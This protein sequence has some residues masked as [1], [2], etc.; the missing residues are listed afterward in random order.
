[1]ND[2]PGP[3]DS[4]SSG[5]TAR[6]F[7]GW[8]VL[9]CCCLLAVFGGAVVHSSTLFVVPMSEELGLTPG[10][11]ALIFLY[12]TA[13]TALIGPLVGWLADRFGSRPLVLIGGLAAGVGL[14]LSS[15]ASSHWQFLATF[16]VAFAGTTAG[17]S[18]I[19]L[20]SL[21]NRW[22]SRRRPV[23]MATLMTMFALG[24]T[25]VPLPVAWG[26][27]ALGWRNSL[28]VLGVFLCVL[29]AIAGMVL[30]NRP[31][32]IALRPNGDPQPPS[33]PDF[34]VREAVRTGAF[35]ALVLGGIVVIDAP[36]SAVE[37]DS[38]VLSV[39]MAL[40]AILLTFVLGVAASRIAARKI[41]A[42]GAAIGAGGYV[43]LAILD[44][45][46]GMLLFHT[47]MAVAQGGIAVYW[48]MVGDYFGRA[49]FASLMGVL[50]FLRAAGAVIPSGIGVLL[51]STGHYEISL[52]FFAVVH[53]AGAVA[54]WLARRPVL[55]PGRPPEEEAVIRH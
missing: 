18:M 43:A 34:R 35:W 29:A 55:P 8:W 39:T 21:V 33:A 20:L 17:F 24:P 30:R 13:S 4:T 40:L 53:I 50:I 10:D 2:H 32:D 45:N 6:P 1:M 44:S 14:L 15:P 9:L 3:N 48:I 41:L 7:Y 31:E 49:R 47:A 27:V 23:A 37:A 28:L 52:L 12:A 11:A 42:A 26:M 51:E 25:L 46:L 54:V 16:A 22:F 5:K 36:N 19:T 38:P